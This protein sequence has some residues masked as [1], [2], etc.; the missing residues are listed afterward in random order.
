MFEE[1]PTA[2]RC[3]HRGEKGDQGGHKIVP[4]QTSTFLTTLRKR[5]GL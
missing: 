2:V 5:N 1:I 4:I 3:D